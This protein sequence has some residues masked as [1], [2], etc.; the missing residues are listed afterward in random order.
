MAYKLWELLR[1]A[2]TELG[3]LTTG[4]ATGGS[5]TT[6]VDTTLVGTG[7]ND[8]WKDGAAIVLY[9]AGGASAAPEG[10]FKRVSAYV[11]STG[12]LTLESAVS[13]AIG[14]GDLYG[15][16]S[17]YYPLRQM[18]EL[19]NLALRSLGDMPLVDTTT[20]DTASNQ[21]EYAC[22]VAW[23][24]RPFRVDI[25][26]NADS[27]DNRWQRTDGWEYIPAAAGT[28]GLIVFKSQPDDG[29]DIRVWYYDQHGRVALFSDVINEHISPILI[30][31]MLVEKALEWQ[32]S[33]LGGTD[34]FLVMR[35][36]DAKN[37]SERA[38]LIYPIS[39]PASFA[40]S[41][42]AGVG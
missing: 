29:Y 21:T 42:F 22:A 23:K 20:L 10:E 16:V 11:D 39:K 2:Y 18:V 32:N 24:R 35:W 9:D 31:A 12:T 5:T 41:R 40:K 15:L 4:L 14:A 36:N 27:N 30:T 25:Q 3:Q 8:D 1:D 37:A 33:R 7:K 17:A 34:E 13:S 28:S 38:R 19:T 26:T 6:I